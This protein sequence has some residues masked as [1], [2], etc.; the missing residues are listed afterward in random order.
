MTRTH[1]RTTRSI[2]ILAARWTQIAEQVSQAASLMAAQRE[3]PMGS[4]DNKA[5]GDEHLRAFEQFVTG[6][7]QVLALLRV[8]AERDENAYVN[9]YLITMN[10]CPVGLKTSV[11]A[12]VRGV[13]KVASPESTS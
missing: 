5:W 3:L 1:G 10:T 4:H 6:Q 8:A 11:T 13:E 12:L 9:A 2:A 7:A